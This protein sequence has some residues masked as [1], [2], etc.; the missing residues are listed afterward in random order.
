MLTLLVLSPLLVAVAVILR[1]TNER[2]VLF[3]QPRI[4]QGN[5]P[6]LVWKFVTMR[7]GSEKQGTITVKNDPRVFPFGRLLRKTKI[8]E[9]PQLLNVIRGRDVDGGA[10]P[11]D[12]GVLRLFSRGG[13]ASRL[14]VQAGAHGDWLRGLQGRR[15]DHGRSQEEHAETYARVMAFKG[16]LELWYLENRS[17]MVDLKIILLTAISRLPTAHQPGVQVVQVELGGAWLGLLSPPDL[18]SPH[19]VFSAPSSAE[20]GSSGFRLLN[21]L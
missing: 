9:L 17:T 3:R 8:N 11:S 21:S 16:A 7:K 20:T 15:R 6:F 18:Y 4:G 1:F 14:P 5:E 13:P 10:A 19:S 2:E 12:R